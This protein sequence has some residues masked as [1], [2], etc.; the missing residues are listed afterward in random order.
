MKNYNIKHYKLNNNSKSIESTKAE[1]S[2][3]ETLIKQIKV[4]EHNINVLQRNMKKFKDSHTLLKQQYYKLLQAENILFKDIFDVS[5][6]K[7]ALG[8]LPS[9]NFE[10]AGRNTDYFVKFAIKHNLDFYISNRF[11]AVDVA[12]YDRQLLGCLLNDNK[13]ILINS[14]LPLNVDSFVEFVMDKPLVSYKTN[15]ELFMLIALAFND[16]RLERIA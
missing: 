1:M 10:K 15:P 6:R 14:G 4:C 16:P 7:K 12:V 11:G 3:Y 5:R 9:G 2:K 8:Y 13:D